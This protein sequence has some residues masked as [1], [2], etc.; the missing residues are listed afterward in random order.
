M[1]T[2]LETQS[3]YQALIQFQTG[4]ISHT[5]FMTVKLWFEHDEPL[6]DEFDRPAAM[7]QLL[8]DML[9]TPAQSLADDLQLNLDGNYISFND[10]VRILLVV[11]CVCTLVSVFCVTLLMII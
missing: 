1:E 5:E 11:C 6:V 2:L 10:L 4:H 3:K 8:F 7:K 9:C